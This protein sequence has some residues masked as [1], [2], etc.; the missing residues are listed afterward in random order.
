MQHIEAQKENKCKLFANVTFCEYFCLWLNK[1]P[2]NTCFGLFRQFIHLQTQLQI[3]HAYI[4]GIDTFYTQLYIYLYT[5]LTLQMKPYSLLFTNQRQYLVSTYTDRMKR[6]GANMEGYT[7]TKAAALL[8]TTR[9]TIY[10]RIKKNPE[11]YTIETA[12]GKTLITLQGLG[13]LKESLNATPGRRVSTV[14]VDKT[15][16]LHNHTIT[17]DEIQRL[18]KV[19][20]AQADELIQ[21][22]NR[23]N[24]MSSKIVN[25]EQDKAFLQ[26]AL[27]K[28]L[29]KRLTLFDRVIKRLTAGK[30]K[31]I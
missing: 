10:N 23:V 24:E 6:Q 31:D 18:E 9:Q 3:C 2:I 22:S 13:L 7:I 11:S 16:A 1:M 17:L 4:Y 29:D 14:E 28:A 19:N 8:S 15:S 27:N 20:A 25:L 30:D 12:D 5:F 26:D 21:V